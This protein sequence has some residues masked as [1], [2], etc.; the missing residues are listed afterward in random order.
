MNPQTQVT[1][2]ELRMPGALQ[3]LRPF[4]L[5][6]AKGYETRREHRLAE[7]CHVL[8]TAIQLHARLDLTEF[9]WEHFHA[10][11]QAASAAY[12]HSE[13][14]EERCMFLMLCVLCDGALDN[15]CCRKWHLSDLPTVVS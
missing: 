14:S 3:E 12:F 13:I 1:P 15:S 10:L 8:A 5:D 4:L 9:G 11:R 7:P 2:G 6:A